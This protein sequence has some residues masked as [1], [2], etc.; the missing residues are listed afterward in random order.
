MMFE[1]HEIVFSEGAESESFYPS[2]DILGETEKA[3]RDEI[4]TLF[5]ELADEPSGY[6][7]PARN[8]LSAGEI[9]LFLNA[10]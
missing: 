7:P 8:A 4:L 2:A 1:Q 10:K 9:D 3:T 6:G 5:P